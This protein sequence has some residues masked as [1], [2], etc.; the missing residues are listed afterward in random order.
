MMNPYLATNRNRPGACRIITAT[1]LA[2]LVCAAAT[3]STPIEIT[4]IFTED[5]A[6]EDFFGTSVDI[7]GDRAIVGNRWDDD[8][9]LNAGSAY[10]YERNANGHW[11]PVAKFL[12]TILSVD[13]EHYAHSVSISG[14]VA[15]VGAYG[16]RFDFTITGAVYV[17]I[18]NGLDIWVPAGVI[19]PNDP[20]AGQG[21]GRSVDLE[22]NTLLVGSSTDS[23]NGINSGSAYIFRNTG[24]W[25]QIDKLLPSD[26]TA[27][28]NFG[29]SCAISGTTAIVGAS[30]NFGAS[31]ASGSAYVFT[32]TSAGPFGENWDQQQ[33]LIASDGT[34]NDLF[35]LEVA[36]ANDTAVIGAIGTG[37]FS[38]NTNF[39]SA[40]VFERNTQDTWIETKI[41]AASTPE[42]GDSFGYDVAI[43]SD[44]ILVSAYHDNENEGSATLF[45]RDSGDWTA[46]AFIEA[47]DGAIG[48]EFGYA[49]AI[50]NDHALIGA[51]RTDDMGASAGSSYIFELD[52]CIA[53]IN[54]DGT[55]DT[56]DLG[57]LIAFFN[58]SNPASDF[59][60]DGTVDTADL[61]ILIAGFGLCP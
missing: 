6:P 14:N 30:S 52:D 32:Q 36:L 43:D 16:T 50:S 38:L 49:I 48:D 29:V 54:G 56:A 45:R 42:P 21:F 55:V 10:I 22:G 51:P 58:S 2:A 20:T 24:S 13:P 27:S 41:L 60:A 8:A 37:V 47:S 7:D 26:P 35:G 53:D 28:A 44:S 31:P 59:N 46:T 34:S 3:A 61:G 39:G 1:A 17:Y 11:V 19:T 4:E 40:Y 57:L 18:R 12:P 5:G 33:K 9:G 23:P 25:T 15:V